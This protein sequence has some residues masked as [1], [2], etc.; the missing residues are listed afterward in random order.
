MSEFSSVG[1]SIESVISAFGFNC[2]PCISGHI[3]I[4]FA[5]F[6]EKMN[7]LYTWTLEKLQHRIMPN[8][9]SRN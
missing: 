4:F 1:F 7:E 9:N 3:L 8:P 5:Q 6:T 2:E